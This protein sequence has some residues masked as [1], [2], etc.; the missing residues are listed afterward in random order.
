MTVKTASD[1]IVAALNAVEGM[2]GR[3][4]SDLGA[5]VN[6]PALVLGPPALMWEGVCDGPTS[7]RFL[8]YAVESVDERA[9]VRL[10]VLVPLVAAA[11]DA[12]PDVS[13]IRAD[14][15]A[16]LAG[17]PE[18]PCYEIQIEVSL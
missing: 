16:Y 1:T 4:T 11:L 5:T 12:L 3:A 8:V 17:G 18:L 15:G 14:P 6:P 7:A 2:T 13:V 10:W 9:L